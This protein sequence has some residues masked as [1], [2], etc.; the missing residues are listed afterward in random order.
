[1]C[2]IFSCIMTM[3]YNFIISFLF[4][5]SI[6]KFFFINTKIFA[7]SYDS[8]CSFLNSLIFSFS[9]LIIFIAYFLKNSRNF[10]KHSLPLHISCLS[11]ILL[12]EDIVDIEKLDGICSLTFAVDEFSGLFLHPWIFFYCTL[13]ICIND[14]WCLIRYLILIKF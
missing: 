9:K 14:K 7:F 6:F 5:I 13:K 8:C 4:Q 3:I 11:F 2:S 12:Y 10:F 1:M